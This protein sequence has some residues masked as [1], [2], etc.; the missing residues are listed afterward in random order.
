MSQAVLTSE[1]TLKSSAAEIASGQTAELSLLTLAGLSAL[2]DPFE[3]RLDWFLRVQLEVTAASGIIPTL[4]TVIED[5]IDGTNYN[6]IGTFAL[7]IAAGREVINIALRGDAQPAG[8]AWPFNPQRIRV[9]WTIAGTT[10]SFTFSVKA[11]LL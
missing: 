7:K 3:N 2:P 1:L 11:V 5:S 9:R 6:V 10:P 4:D 8:F